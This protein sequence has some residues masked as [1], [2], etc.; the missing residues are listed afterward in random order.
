MTDREITSEGRFE[1]LEKQ[2]KDLR[3]EVDSLRA[4]VESVEGDQDRLEQLEVADL[5]RRLEAAERVL[6]P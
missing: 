3:D 2:V 4:R 1:R 5:K 6:G